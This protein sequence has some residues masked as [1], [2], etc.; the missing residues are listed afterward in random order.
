MKTKKPKTDQKGRK[1]M[2]KHRGFSHDYEFIDDRNYKR[3]R[4]TKD[5]KTKEY[6]WKWFQ[7]HVALP[8][9]DRAAELEVPKKN[10]KKAVWVAEWP[11]GT[12]RPTAI[13]IT[14]PHCAG[15]MNAKDHEIKADGELN[16]CIVCPQCHKHN[17]MKL[18]DWVAGPLKAVHNWEDKE[19]E[20]RW[21]RSVMER[22][23][24]A[25]D[26]PVEPIT[27]PTSDVPVDPL[28]ETKFME[29]IKEVPKKEQPPPIRR[30]WPW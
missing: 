10:R 27:G 28:A 26:A 7:F 13:Y 12:E 9:I 21:K 15:M 30:W 5:E 29:P 16:P 20:K 4:R 3:L 19:W 18:L 25:L 6:E 11:E 23:E 2:N 1:K 24:G 22:S 17:F 14:C 8:V